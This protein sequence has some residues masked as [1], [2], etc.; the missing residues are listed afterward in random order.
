MTVTA[1]ILFAVFFIR[2]KHEITQRKCKKQRN[3][4]NTMIFYFKVISNIIT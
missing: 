4:N 2:G 3:N 1:K